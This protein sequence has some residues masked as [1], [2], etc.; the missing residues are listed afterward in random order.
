MAVR[1]AI[2]NKAFTNRIIDGDTDP[3]YT[4][5]LKNDFFMDACEMVHESIVNAGLRF[6]VAE[7]TLALDANN[8]YTL[9]TDFYSLIA[10]A[11][12]NGSRLE[13]CDENDSELKGRQGFQKR[14]DQI[15]L[16]GYSAFPAT[17][18]LKYYHQPK[19]F[20]SWD[21]TADPVDTP[22]NIVLHSPDAPLNSA[23]G[24]RT[25]S[26]IISVLALAE[27][28]DL[29]PEKM[30]LALQAAERFV[31]RLS[32]WNTEPQYLGE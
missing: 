22:E 29:T 30:E 20:D 28:E 14:N 24:A 17:L 5:D 26:K 8:R 27:D 19:A 18:T 23:G 13:E 32:G 11:D 31:N 6:F 2:I 16:I 12:S 7:A 1:S 25:L 10:L 4:P 15:E 3:L 21:G 9:P